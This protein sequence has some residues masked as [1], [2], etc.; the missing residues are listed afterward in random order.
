MELTGKI[1]NWRIHKL[2]ITE[3][4]IEKKFGNENLQPMV[5]SGVVVKD[6]RNRWNPGNTMRSSLIKNIKG[7][8]VKTRNS[9]YELIGEGDNENSYFP[10][11]G[12]GILNVFW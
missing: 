7:N 11:M 2:S 8:I 6:Y 1:S 4:E 5:L 10:D 12:D 9:I 3:E